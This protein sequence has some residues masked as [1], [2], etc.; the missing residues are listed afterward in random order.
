MNVNGHR[1]QSEAEKGLFN[2]RV[3]HR[4]DAE[5]RLT[6]TFNALHNPQSQDPGGLSL[7]QAE[8]DPSQATDNAKRLNSGQSV[9]QQTLG[10]NTRITR[11]YRVR[12]R[13]TPSTVIVTSPS[14]YHSRARAAW[15][16][17]ATFTE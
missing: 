1:E 17:I 13:L 7:A 12:S 16:L 9:N 14:S 11:C 3:S 8:A 6:A 4:L 2:A 10:F 5:R 15:H